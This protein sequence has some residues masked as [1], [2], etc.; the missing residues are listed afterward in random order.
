MIT[1]LLE[2]RSDRDPVLQVVPVGGP[3]EVV[4][5]SLQPGADQAD[6]ETAEQGDEQEGTDLLVAFALVPGGA[7]TA[8]IPER[9]EFRLG[10]STYQQVHSGL[11]QVLRISSITWWT[12]LST[13]GRKIMAVGWG[14]RLIQR[15]PCTAPPM[16]WRCEQPG[17][18]V[19]LRIASTRTLFVR[20]TLDRDRGSRLDTALVRR[21]HGL[22][23]PAHR[24]SHRTRLPLAGCPDGNRHGREAPPV[25]FLVVG[26]TCCPSE[27]APFRSPSTRAILG[28]GN[29][30]LHSR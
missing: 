15:A 5:A 13:Q 16:I 3:A 20:S 4:A 14:Q 23:R 29:G 21:A 30:S 19:A 26:R 27:R 8:R 17:M 28:S 24:E 10:H 9:P 6:C 1:H 22:E 25:R 2:C 11:C 7:Q 12:R 18:S